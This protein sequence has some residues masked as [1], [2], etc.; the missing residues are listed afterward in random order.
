MY[1][2]NSNQDLKKLFAVV[3]KLI[4]NF[5]WKFVSINIGKIRRKEKW[6]LGLLDI[7]R[8]CK[9]FLRYCHI[10]MIT[11]G[12]MKLKQIYS[13]VDRH[14]VYFQFWVIKSSAT[15]NIF[16]QVS[17]VY[18]DIYTFIWYIYIEGELQFVMLSTP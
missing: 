3:D 10:S 14:L 5:F 18:I 1:L 9:E 4:W 8:Q 16:A 12:Q 11:S 15:V 6:R 2:C 17:L 13:T 7:S